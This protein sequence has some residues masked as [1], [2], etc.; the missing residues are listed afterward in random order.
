LIEKFLGDFYINAPGIE[1]LK[2][3]PEVR[4]KDS[5]FQLPEEMADKYPGK[6]LHLIPHSI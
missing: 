3:F 2:S 1:F 4:I 6:G 5:S